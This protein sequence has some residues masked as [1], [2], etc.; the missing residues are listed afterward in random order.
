MGV[1]GVALAITVGVYLTR[2]DEREIKRLLDQGK[3]MECVSIA[4]QYL[5]KHPE[6][7]QASAL[8]TECL[9]KAVVPAWK[10]KLLAREF[11]GANQILTQ[12]RVTSQFSA[13]GL[14]LLE[15]LQWM[16]DLEK[17]VAD[18]GGLL[19]PIIMFKHEATIDLLVERWRIDKAEYQRLMSK[20][21]GIYPGV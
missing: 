12:A 13:Q 20:N 1:A 14:T 21:S 18:R 16:T 4:N 9:L 10:A 15:V 2:A 17:F 8:A 5:D 7:E 6:D 11:A 3:Y 19:A